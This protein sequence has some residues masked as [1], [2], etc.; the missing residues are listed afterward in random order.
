[1]PTPWSAI[2]SWEEARLRGHYAVEYDA[3]ARV[4]PRWV[5]RLSGR[6]RAANQAAPFVWRDVAFSERGTLIA[7]LA[8]AVL[9]LVKR[10]LI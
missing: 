4:V 10:L 2:A 7:A 9:T 8:M 6:W 3:Y 5:P 1:M